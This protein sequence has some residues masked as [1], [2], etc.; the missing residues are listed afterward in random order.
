MEDR[1]DAALVRLKS[2]VTSICTA[3]FSLESADSAISVDSE[4]LVEKF[5]FHPDFVAFY[6]AFD[7]EGFYLSL[8]HFLVSV[9]IFD[10]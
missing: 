4:K 3:I 2:Y 9:I 1:D 5:C 10:M 6:V 8:L 7:S